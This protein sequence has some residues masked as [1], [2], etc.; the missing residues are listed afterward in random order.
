MY[1]DV[2]PEA[3]AAGGG[4]ERFTV[5]LAVFEQMLEAIEHAGLQ[6]CSLA[7]A[8]AHGGSD[9]VAITFDDGTLGQFDHAV[10][11][12]RARDMTATFF[13]TT[14]WVGR[15]GFMS[16]DQLRRLKAWGMSVQSHSKSHA[17]LSELDEAH[18]RVELSESKEAL[19]R[20]LGQD[21]S[22]I[23]LPA[24]NAPKLGLR[25]ILSDA[26][27][28]VVATSRW[29]RNREARGRLAGEPR[30]I[31]RCT[32][33]RLTTPELAHRI[34]T[35]DLRLAAV[36]YPRE[37]VLNGIRAALGASRYA[38]WRRRVLD[39]VARLRPEQR[40]RAE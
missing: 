35:G 16:W 30:W 11:A 1:H 17:H 31:R 21:T 7:D 9:R 3:R 15:R 40:P 5:S 22:Q 38:R 37:A 25:S 29:G 27:Y 10:P 13:V 26:G 8:L 18:L 14:D 28:G 32:A 2:A 12:L 34:V 23:A 6:G 39:A 33:P 4:P 36:T 20:H 19:D 24:G